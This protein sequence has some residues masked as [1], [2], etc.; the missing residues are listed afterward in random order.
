MAEKTD[1]QYPSRHYHSNPPLT[2][3]QSQAD[4]ILLPFQRFLLGFCIDWDSVLTEKG[5]FY[6]I[7]IIHI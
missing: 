7:H 2:L 4:T 5:S 1:L 6:I 3:V